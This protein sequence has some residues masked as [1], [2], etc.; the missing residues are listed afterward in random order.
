MSYRALALSLCALASLHVPD[1]RSGRASEGK[2]D[3]D[4][5][6]LAGENLAIQDLHPKTGDPRVATGSQWL[7]LCR[8]SRQENMKLDIRNR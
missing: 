1:A 6:R 2:F 8:I 4:R 3:R 7:A 5:R